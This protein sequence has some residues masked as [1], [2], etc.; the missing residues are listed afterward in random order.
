LII[1]TLTFILSHR[2][3]KKKKYPVSGASKKNLFP[4]PLGEGEGEGGIWIGNLS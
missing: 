2:Q 3:R 4:L 1:R